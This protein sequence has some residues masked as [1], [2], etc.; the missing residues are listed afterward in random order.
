MSF[1]GGSIFTCGQKRKVLKR[2]GKR[3]NAESNASARGMKFQKKDAE[4]AR[5]L[6]PKNSP[7]RFH[8][9]ASNRFTEQKARKTVNKRRITLD[10]KLLEVCVL[11][12][13]VLLKHLAPI[14]P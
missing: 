14:L 10:N 13:F 3:N 1:R 4:L 7:K 9:P 12:T 5:I 2:A 11:S 6:V 8:D